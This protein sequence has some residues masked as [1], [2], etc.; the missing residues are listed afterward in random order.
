MLTIGSAEDG[1]YHGVDKLDAIVL[2]RVVTGGDH[3]TNGLAIELARAQRGQ[4]SH[5]VDDRVEDLA[6]DGELGYIRI[7]L[8]K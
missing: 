6:E 8:S 4:E 2:G 1:V 5:T 7:K 3:N